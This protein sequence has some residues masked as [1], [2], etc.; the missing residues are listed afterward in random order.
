MRRMFM[1]LSAVGICLLSSAQC[2]EGPRPN[3]WHPD[4]IDSFKLLYPDCDKYNYQTTMINGEYVKPKLGTVNDKI[5]YAAL[6]VLMLAS[7][8][9]VLKIV[10]TRIEYFT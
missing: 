8:I 1:V 3:F 2:P 9:Y 4:Q 10:T 6:L 5:F 7:I